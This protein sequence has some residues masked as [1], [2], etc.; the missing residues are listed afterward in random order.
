MTVAY[1]TVIGRDLLTDEALLALIDSHSEGELRLA[2]ARDGAELVG[3]PHVTRVPLYRDDTAGEVR[4]EPEAY[5][6]RA[7]HL[8]PDMPA[9]LLIRWEQPTRRRVWNPPITR[10]RRRW[11]LR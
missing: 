9:A 3:R 2:A 5:L 1:W 11:R 10:T 8:V 4:Y 6:R 7:G